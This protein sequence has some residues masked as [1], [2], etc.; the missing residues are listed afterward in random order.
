MPELRNSAELTPE[1]PAEPS[2]LAQAYMMYP[3]AGSRIMTGSS[4]SSSSLLS[5]PS[6]PMPTA[7]SFLRSPFDSLL[8]I[9]SVAEEVRKNED[10][11]LLGTDPRSPYDKS[12]SQDLSSSS[13]IHS[14]SPDYMGEECDSIS[15]EAR[16]KWASIRDLSASITKRART[17]VKTGIQREI[18]HDVRREIE[19]MM[20][21]LDSIA[22]MAPLDDCADPRSTS[23]RSPIIGGSG[24]SSSAGQ[25]QD[26]DYEPKR[27]PL[28]TPSAKRRRSPATP[29][30]NSPYCLSCGTTHTPEWRK[31]P[32]GKKSLCNACGL[33]Y[34]K[35]IKR[36]VLVPTRADGSAAQQMKVNSLLN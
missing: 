18:L 5:A 10:V 12:P 33:H 35:M 32:D 14:Q 22:D 3:E 7:T 13:P 28:S 24:A 19:Q 8:Y 6:A 29:K 20:E 17:G 34:A 27:V 9:S 16:S 4:S 25:T 23:N 31:G 1:A 15:S 21:C 30:N 26:Q 11:K 2:H 36:E